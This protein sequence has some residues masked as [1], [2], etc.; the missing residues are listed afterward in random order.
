MSNFR[1]GLN[2]LLNFVS[3]DY[4]GICEN[5]IQEELTKLKKAKDLKATQ[6]D[7]IVKARVGQGAFRKD[8]LSYWKSCVLTGCDIKNLLIASYIKPWCD[9]DNKER[10]DVFNGLLLLPTYDKL[11]YLGYIT[12]RP[13][14]LLA[15][16]KFLPEASKPTLGLHPSLRVAVTKHHEPY[17]KHHNQNCFMG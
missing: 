10:L 8:L 15:V 16:S 12:I 17:L 7:I 13:S 2:K 4:E 9:S 11:F 14:G 3:S 1:A 6:K 5:K